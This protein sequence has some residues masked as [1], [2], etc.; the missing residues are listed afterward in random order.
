MT[1][2]F[3]NFVSHVAATRREFSKTGEPIEY[4]L[5]GL[6]VLTP[7]PERVVIIKSVILSNLISAV[8]K[9]LQ[10]NSVRLAENLVWSSYGHY[11]GAK[12]TFCPK[13]L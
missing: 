7:V 12:A 13:N 10:P 9:T 3:Q 11:Y 8:S 1:N 5:Y 2:N 4:R 6:A